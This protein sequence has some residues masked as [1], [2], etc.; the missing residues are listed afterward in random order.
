MNE[1]L[2]YNSNYAAFVY[3]QCRCHSWIL[4]NIRG[5]HFW[6]RCVCISCVCLIVGLTW[7]LYLIHT[8]QEQRIPGTTQLS[9]V[10]TMRLF[11]V[12]RKHVLSFPENCNRS[13]FFHRK[14]ML[15][16]HLSLVDQHSPL[17]RQ[18]A[19]TLACSFRRSLILIQNANSDVFSQFSFRKCSRLDRYYT[20]V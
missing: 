3:R 16:P 1:K 2:E 10:P 14:C 9:R 18:S 13:I 6:K 20:K 12:K 17:V 8:F 7:S 11:N 19:T 4:L 15:S 5:P